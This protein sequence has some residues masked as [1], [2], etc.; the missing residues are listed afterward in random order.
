MFTVLGT[1]WRSANVEFLA[2]CR[3][4][5]C[6]NFA[7]KKVQLY[8]EEELRKHINHAV[9][10]WDGWVLQMVNM[11]LREALVQR[12]QLSKR[13]LSQLKQE[14]GER[15]QGQEMLPGQAS[16]CRCPAWRTKWWWWWWRLG[17]VAR[18]SSTVA[19]LDARRPSMGGPA[20]FKTPARVWD[21]GIIIQAFQVS[22]KTWNNPRGNVCVQINQIV[23]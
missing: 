17:W 18:M 3:I 11:S 7:R 8:G 19:Y 10:P 15:L 14:Q 23:Q 1:V 12:C 13:T 20:R 6:Q 2:L 5:V 16:Q 21:A 4:L 9:N 22:S